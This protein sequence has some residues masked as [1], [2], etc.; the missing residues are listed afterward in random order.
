MTGREHQRR[1]AVAAHKRALILDAARR[2]F[3]AHGLEG[4]S[5]RAIAAEAGYTA[6]ALY[7]HFPSKE[8]IYGALLHQSLAALA[9]RVTGASE[10]RTEPAA[11][12]RAGG[13]AFFHYYAENPR[14]LDLGFYL[15][16]G[17]MK[18]AGLGRDMDA[19]LNHALAAALT[20]IAEAAMTMGASQDAA[21]R[22]VVGLFAH[23]AGLLLLLHTGRLRMFDAAAAD[24]MT[25][26]LDA[27]IRELPP[28]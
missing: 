5:M 13:M 3:E 1:Q 24:L 20:P 8:A 23:A 16:R 25:D 28:C 26:Y 12:I 27:L 4:A 19:A 7:F 10:N 18:P 11:K 17:G 6:A 22:L 21:R 15:L 9:A 2:V 14:D